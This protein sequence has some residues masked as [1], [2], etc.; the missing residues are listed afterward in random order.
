MASGTIPNY[1]SRAKVRLRQEKVKLF[2][3]FTRKQDCSLSEAHAFLSM[4]ALSLLSQRANLALPESASF[5]LLRQASSPSK[6]TF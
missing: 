3:C 4:L 5:F 2:G 6:P 1:P